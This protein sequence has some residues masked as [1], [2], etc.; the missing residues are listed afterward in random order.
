M[1][2]LKWKL[3]SIRL[4]IVLILMQMGAFFMPN[5]TKARK[6]FW[7]YPMELL[8]DVGHVKSHFSPFGD[9]VSVSA[10]LV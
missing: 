8:G 3:I 9:G 10:R 6:S 2:R 5:E 1:L 7:T 4:E